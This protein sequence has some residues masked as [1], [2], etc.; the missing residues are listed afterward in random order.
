[1]SEKERLSREL[2]ALRLA[3]E[4]KPGMVVNLGIGM[5]TLV[6]DYIPHDGSLVLHS[7]NGVIGFGPTPREGEED[8]NLVNAG[9]GFITLLPGG[10]FVSHADAFAMIRGGHVDVAV[11]GGLQVSEQGDLANWLVPPRALGSPGGAVDLCVGA[12]QVFV[13]MEHTTRDGKPRLV[14]RCTYSLT[15]ARCVSLVMTDLGLFQVTPQ[16]FLLREIAPGWTAAEVR[17]LTEAPL[18]V[19]PELVEVRA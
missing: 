10:A 19:G 12:K 18:A 13:V 15:G 4:L 5:P 17:S 6:S 11:L 9:G 16:G 7:E 2:M 3:R 14:S 1:M 8:P